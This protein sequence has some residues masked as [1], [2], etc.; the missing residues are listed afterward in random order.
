MC[1]Q[2]V[3]CIHRFQCYINHRPKKP[4]HIELHRPINNTKYLFTNQHTVCRVCRIKRPDCLCVPIGGTSRTNNNCW[5]DRMW[6]LI[7]MKSK[8][9]TMSSNWFCSLGCNAIAME[10]LPIFFHIDEVNMRTINTI[11]LKF[12]ANNWARAVNTNA[13]W[14][15]LQCACVGA[16]SRNVCIVLIQNFWTSDNRLTI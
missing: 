12:C 3:R 14:W 4:A 9:L 11:K 10:C 15:C 6:K 2:I 13:K 16:Y 1:A 5:K 7:Q 8:C